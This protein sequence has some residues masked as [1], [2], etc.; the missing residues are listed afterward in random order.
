MFDITPKHDFL[1][2]IDSDGCAFD[3]MEVKHK[4][5]FIPAIV[6]YYNL[7]GVSKYAREAAE[8]VNLYSKSRG[9]NRFPAL[10]EALDHL[11]QRPEVKA[12]GVEIRAVRGLVDW[13]KRETKLGNPALEAAVKA[14]GDPDLEQALAWS[15]AVNEAVER[16]VRGVPPFP[17]VRECLEKLA[18]K[19]DLFVV[20]AT[21]NEALTREWEEH[22]LSKYVC[23]ICGQEIGTKKESLT[24]AKKYP[25]NHT[26]MIGDAPGD[27]QAAKANAALFFPIN[28]GHEDASWKRLHDEGIDRFL[29]GTFAGEYQNKLLAEFDTHLPD[30]P[31]WIKN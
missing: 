8:F 16:I 7:A 3:T 29:A 6:N 26:L 2:G 24:N 23:A 5:C 28:P 20:S 25:A 14:T 30:K 19:A 11:K 15:K 27:Q 13:M 12:R 1:V 17:Y 31:P 10:I 9:I 22:D 4:E 18:P 21:P